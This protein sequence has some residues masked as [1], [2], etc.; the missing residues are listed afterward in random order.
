M[1]ENVIYSNEQ[2]FID[3]LSKISK[4]WNQKIHVLADFDRT[5]TTAFFDG[6]S[7]PS[8]ISV[9]RSENYLTQEYSDKAYALFDHFHPIEV[10]PNIFLE[11]KKLQM[12]QWWQQH[13]SLLVDSKLHKSHIEKVVES[14]II[15]LREGVIPFLKYL[16]QHNIPLVIISANGLGTDSIKM[17]LEKQSLLT[18]NVHII[19]NEFYWDEVG[20][21]SGYDTRVIHTFNKDETVLHDFP[22]IFEEV[23]EKTNVILLW[24]S[25]WDPG[26]IEGFEYENLLKIGF[27]NEKEDELLE[28]YKK[29]YDLIL[30]WDYS[31]DLCKIVF[32]N[33]KKIVLV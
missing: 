7:R 21:A 3:T 11:E 22:E 14:G 23:K 1:Q 27:L 25:L 12:T 2:N 20:F 16:D 8:L 18:K 9:L 30:T 19:S 17:Y 33:F 15:E 32:P 10:D 4:D 29:H 5:L 6:K 26:M 24:D 13:L 28:E 31:W